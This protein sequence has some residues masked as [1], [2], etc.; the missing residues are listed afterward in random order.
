MNHLFSETSLECRGVVHNAP[1]DP[2]G[3]A[4]ALSDTSVIE[5]NKFILYCSQLAL[6]LQPEI[7]K[8]IM[9][10]INGL[11]IQFGKRALFQDV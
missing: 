3:I 10:T 2:H 11:D 8:G 4:D 1:T 9:I 7:K 6:S 5:T